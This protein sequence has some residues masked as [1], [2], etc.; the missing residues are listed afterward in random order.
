MEIQNSKDIIKK[1]EKDG[2]ENAPVFIEILRELAN[3]VFYEK[4]GLDKRVRVYKREP[5]RE[6]AQYLVDR[7]LGRIPQRTELTG[8]DGKDLIPREEVERVL[9][10]IYLE[11]PSEKDVETAK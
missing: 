8:K 9:K 3:G 7:A 10:N 6:A 4:V 11:K 2:V 5:D 1:L